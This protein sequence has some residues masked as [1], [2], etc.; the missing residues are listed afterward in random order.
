[1]RL[2]AD[3]ES[4][5]PFWKY[6]ELA[7]GRAEFTWEGKLSETVGIALKGRRFG[8]FAEVA[9]LSVFVRDERI[10]AVNDRCD[11]VTISIAVHQV[12]VT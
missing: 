1:M 11:L 5:S 8:D 3:L 10:V 12:Q 2:Y 7:G 9:N 4:S 6:R